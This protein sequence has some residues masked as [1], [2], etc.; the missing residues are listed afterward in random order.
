MTKMAIVN[1]AKD[2]TP[3]LT[4]HGNTGYASHGANTKTRGYQSRGVAASFEMSSTRVV[5]VLLRN[6][7]V[8]L[9]EMSQSS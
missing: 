5:P 8:R 4:L 1:R 7:S 3:V 2:V 6:K 9:H